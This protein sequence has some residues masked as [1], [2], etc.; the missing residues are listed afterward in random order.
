MNNNESSGIAL[1]SEVIA[2]PGAE[3][4]LRLGE[5]CYVFQALVTFIIECSD[6][7]HHNVSDISWFDAIEKTAGNLKTM[8]E[9]KGLDKIFGQKF[10]DKFD[11]LVK[12]RNK[13]IHSLACTDKIFNTNCNQGFSYY[14]KD[15]GEHFYI[16]FDFLTKFIVDCNDLERQLD[17]L[18]SKGLKP[19]C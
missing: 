4:L 9:K 2:L 5:A 10:L 1:I 16:D 8:L 3:Y 19:S 12:R 17:E 7:E 15:K 13:I 11:D 18:R 6:K 14:D